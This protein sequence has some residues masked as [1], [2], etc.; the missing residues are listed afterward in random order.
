MDN[1]DD[2]DNDNDDTHPP[3]IIV[4]VGMVFR[5]GQKKAIKKRE[6]SIDNM[7]CTLSS[8][9]KRAAARTKQIDRQLK[10]DYERVSKV[11]Q[12]Q[13]TLGYSVV[14]IYVRHLMT[15]QS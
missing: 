12:D 13:G 15:R 6:L 2:N 1:D 11:H 4:R 3:R 14:R 7:G 5:R 10:Y 9:E 8:D